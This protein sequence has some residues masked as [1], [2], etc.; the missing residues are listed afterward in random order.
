MTIQVNE[1][2]AVADG[3]NVERM[4]LYFK[5][6]GID[7]TTGLRARPP[8]ECSR[9]RI[10]KDLTEFDRIVDHTGRVSR[11]RRLCRECHKQGNRV[12]TPAK[13]K[14][15]KRPQTLMCA[16]CGTDGPRDDFRDRRGTMTRSCSAC[17]G[18]CLK[19]PYGWTLCPTCG[20][21]K[22]REEFR[23]KDRQTMHRSAPFDTCF[24][25]R[26]V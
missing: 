11:Y 16:T 24:D 19:P 3:I 23:M 12:R 2:A 17:R 6:R 15:S 9:C 7:I 22:H 10:A 21:R 26:G 5:K 18:M 14:P 8:R 20:E 13:P 1:L 4:A 25:C